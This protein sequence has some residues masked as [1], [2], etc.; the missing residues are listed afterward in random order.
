[1]KARIG[2]TS[3]E[4]MTPTQRKLCEAYVESYW[5]EVR[6]AINDRYFYAMALALSDVFGFGEKRVIRALNAVGEIVIGYGDE[7]YTPKERRD[8]LTDIKKMADNMRQELEKR[9]IDL[10]LDNHR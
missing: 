10:E 1:M 8:M 7:T 4:S 9:G 2:K 6:A 3:F 5:H